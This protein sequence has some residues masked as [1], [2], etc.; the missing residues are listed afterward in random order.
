MLSLRLIKLIETHAE[1]LTREVVEDLLTNEHTPSFRRLT[2][3]ELEPRVFRFY[4]GLGNWI[5]DP[6]DVTVQAEY[7]E[8]GKIRCHQGIPMSEIVYCLILTKKHLRRYIRDHGLVAFS[9]DLTVSEGLAPLELYSIQ[10]LN[11]AVGDF[12]DQAL[13]HLTLGYEMQNVAERISAGEFDPQM[14]AR[15]SA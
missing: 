10:E 14:K 5:C 13:Y 7:E 15:T 9:G 1:S 8:W 2:K 11:Y 6:N 3:A 4:H 12:F